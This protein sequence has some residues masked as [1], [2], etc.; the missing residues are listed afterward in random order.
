MQYAH[1]YTCTIPLQ[2]HTHPK[3]IIKIYIFSPISWPRNVV[4]WA[5][6]EVPMHAPDLGDHAEC[7]PLWDGLVFGPC[8]T[9][10]KSNMWLPT[11]MGLS[12]A[13]GLDWLR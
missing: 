3:I 1:E 2:Y 9:G 6:L 10:Q 7:C 4:L 13:Y 11:N 12:T 8:S 5:Q